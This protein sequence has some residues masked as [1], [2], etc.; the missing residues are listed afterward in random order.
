MAYLRSKNADIKIVRIFNTYG[1]R[2]RPGDGRVISNFITQALTGKPIT[3][4]GDGNQTR[5]FSYVSDLVKG[6]VFMMNSRF[7]GPKNLGNPEEYTVLELAKTILKLTGSESKIIFEKL[8]VDDPT[9]RQPDISKARELLSWEPIVGL[10]EGLNLT[11]DWFRL[12]PLI[13]KNSS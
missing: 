1:P 7:V 4:Y 11:I 8:P 5:S 10:E 2:L 3:I 13:K 6:L 9:K 12:L